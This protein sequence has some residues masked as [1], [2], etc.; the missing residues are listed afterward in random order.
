MRRPTIRNLSSAAGVSIS[1]VN[2]VLAG[3]AGVRP[4]TIRAVR[5]AAEAI[6]FYGLR[7]IESRVA[8]SKPRYRL[9]FLLHQPGRTFYR[10]MAQALQAAAQA[11]DDCEIETVVE[12]LEELSPQ[13]TAAR[14][15]A[16]GERCDA[17]G[18]VAA[19]HPLVTQAVDALRERR[20]PVFA[21]I[22][23]LSATGNVHY[24]GVD[25]WKVGRT[26]AWAIEHIAKGPGKL[27]ILVGNHRYR[28]QEMNESGFRS[29]F[30]EHAPDFQILE[31][32]STFESATVAQEVTERLL[33]AHPDLIGLY[34]AG[35]GITGALAALRATGRAGKLIVVGYELM[36][37]TRHALIDGAMTLVIS[38]PLAELAAE[39]VEGMIQIG[40]KPGESNFTRVLSFDLYTRENI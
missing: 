1:T 15:L 33:Q 22:S 14:M 29:Y 21:L 24:V 36:D 19:V 11:R 38:H 5:N 6:G 32:V 31:P 12:F 35:G 40:S 20:I 34:V 9:G 23:Q 37:P 17:I 2:R 18:V 27:G 8:A 13:N 28:C 10:N 25:N 7:S 39:A 4:E 26:A 30:R 3:S 16:L